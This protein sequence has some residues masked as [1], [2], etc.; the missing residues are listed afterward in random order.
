MSESQQ[1]IRTAFEQLTAQWSTLT[2]AEMTAWKN[3]KNSGE[4][5]IN[6]PFTGT[7][8][9]PRSAKDLFVQV[10]MNIFLGS[11]YSLSG[12]ITTPAVKAAPN[13][14][15]FTAAAAAAGAGTFT[16]TY[17]GNV[18]AEALCI[19]ATPPL[20]AGSLELPPSKLRIID[21]DQAGASPVNI[22]AA[23]TGLFGAITAQA[24]KVIFIK[25]DSINATTGQRRVVGVQ[26]IVI[27]A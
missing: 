12:T 8:R 9:N 24:G 15:V 16:L 25:I 21:P 23:Y 5:T 1:T 17:T 4:W 10:N 3:A 11:D 18:G 13:D 26:R 22:A 6:D 2:Q 27:A 14:V 7:S 19:S 20:S